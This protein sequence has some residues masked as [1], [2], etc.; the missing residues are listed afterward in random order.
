MVEHVLPVRPVIVPNSAL[1]SKSSHTRRQYVEACKTS[2]RALFEGK[3]QVWIA[4]CEDLAVQGGATINPDEAGGPVLEGLQARLNALG[5][6]L[7][8]EFQE[9]TVS[10]P[11][12]PTPVY[13]WISEPPYYVC[14][15][16][17]PSS[18]SMTYDEKSEEVEYSNAPATGP[19]VQ[20]FFSVE[21]TAC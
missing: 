2:L 9:A 17:E 21:C 10:S 7:P 3:Q 5:S 12:D 19:A 15:H 4:L 14:E 1:Q 16:Q 13:R 11:Q 8:G 18:L 6:E 20:L